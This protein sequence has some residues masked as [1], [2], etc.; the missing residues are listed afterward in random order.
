MST[1]QSSIIIECKSEEQLN[2]LISTNRR[3]IVL[4]YSYAMP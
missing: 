3:V 1:H 2:E 4:Y